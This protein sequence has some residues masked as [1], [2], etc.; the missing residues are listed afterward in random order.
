MKWPQFTLQSLF[1]VVTASPFAVWL[2]RTLF[3]ADSGYARLPA[4]VASFFIC[5]IQGGAFLTWL[6]APR[7]DE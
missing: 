4:I 7:A 3:A 2:L 5:M 6:V 1:L